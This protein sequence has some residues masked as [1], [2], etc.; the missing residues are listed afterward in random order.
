M[1]PGPAV[2]GILSYVLLLCCSRYGSDLEV[3]AYCA[4]SNHHHLVVTDRKGGADSKVSNFFRDLHGILGRS[5][6][7]LQHRSGVVWD[8]NTSFSDVE[9][10]GAEAELAQW[11]YAAGQA[12]AAGLVE[13]P[14]DWPG[15]AWLP[16]DIGRTLTARRPEVLFSTQVVEDPDAEDEELRLAQERLR[17]QLAEKSVK[18]KKRGRTR[19]RR[20]QLAKERQARVDLPAPKPKPRPKSGLPEVVSYTVPVPKFLRDAGMDVAEARAYLRAALDSY[21]A[22]IHAERRERG[23]GYV[24]REA[25]LD[26]PPDLPPPGTRVAAEER[27][28]YARN[29][30]L[31]TRG[32]DK[33]EVNEIKGDLIRWHH[34]YREGVE[35]LLRS[36]TPHRARFP[37]GAHRQA[38]VL[39]RVLIAYSAQ[40]PPRAA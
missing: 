16:E 35:T 5:L 27:A 20:K 17:R 24:G 40:A 28:T 21:V 9:I 31:A 33:E 32:L 13:R 2:N 15:V 6:N 25:L 19:R 8:P 11:V 7:Y 29:P 26:R 18:D 4:L 1:T 38:Q 22:Q 14:E 10:H 37:E 3:T 36:P 34:D 23:V 30:R 39:R 12:V